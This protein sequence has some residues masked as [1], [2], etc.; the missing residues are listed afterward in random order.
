MIKKNKTKQHLFSSLFKNK[1]GNKGACKR[2]HDDI[3]MTG[4][5]VYVW[6]HTAQE[7]VLSM[8]W[9]LRFSLSENSL[10][11]L[12]H[13]EWLEVIDSWGFPGSWG[14]KDSS[15]KQEMQVHCL[16]PEDSLDKEVAICSCNLVWEIPQRSLAS[17]SPWCHK[18]SE[19]T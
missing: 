13:Q 8:F 10:V 16:G 4:I 9:S 1:Y 2:R 3:W 14:I 12:K 18:E 11:S 5:C 7:G 15:A 19:V 17:C 6:V